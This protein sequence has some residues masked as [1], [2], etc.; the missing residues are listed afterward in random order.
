MELISNKKGKLIIR[1]AEY[2][3]IKNILDFQQ[4]HFNFS[5]PAHLK[6]SLESL[7]GISLVT[8]QDNKVMGHLLLIPLTSKRNIGLEEAILISGIWLLTEEAREVLLREA[9]MCAWESGF[10]AVFSFEAY[11]GLQEVGFGPIKKD[12]FA[13]DISNYAIYGMELSW[14]G[15]NLIHKDLTIP[16]TYLPPIKKMNDFSKN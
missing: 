14:N 8:Y 1:R 10:H 11:D 13:I 2:G 16:K 3:D 12:F 6:N 7:S 5:Q 15:F 4:K 9:M